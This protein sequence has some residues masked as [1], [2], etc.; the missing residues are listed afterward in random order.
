MQAFF[1]LYGAGVFSGMHKK[2]LN[3]IQSND[4]YT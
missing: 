1:H 3:K 4:A 2:S